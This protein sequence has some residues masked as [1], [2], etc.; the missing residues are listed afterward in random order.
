MR[1]SEHLLHVGL[2]P[3]ATRRKQL[4]PVSRLIGLFRDNA[5]PGCELRAAPTAASGSIVCRDSICGTHKLPR[6]VPCRLVVRQLLDECH[7]GQSELLC[8][9]L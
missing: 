2:R 9:A 7:D 6:K 4:E 8:A 5:D 1:L 3:A